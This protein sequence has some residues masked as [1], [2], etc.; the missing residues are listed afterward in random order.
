MSTPVILYSPNGKP[1]LAGSTPWGDVGMAIEPVRVFGNFKAAT[2]SGV[3]TQT[4]V[5]CPSGQAL[6]VTDI[7]L[8]ADKTAL[9]TATVRFY[10]GTNTEN[11][12]VLDT[13]EI[14]QSL[15]IHPAGRTLGWDGA[16]VQLVTDAAQQAATL[17]V[18]FVRVSGDFV[19][20]YTKWAAERG[21]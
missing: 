6:Y 16:Y 21:M 11:I 17:T 3:Q 5:A 12:V 8:S 13:A 14:A 2:N 15:A 10:D 20:P 1:L 4:V 7:V 9:S 18:W 19:L